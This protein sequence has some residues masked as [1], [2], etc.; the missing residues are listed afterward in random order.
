M[1]GRLADAPS[2][3]FVRTCNSIIRQ[4]AARRTEVARQGVRKARGKGSWSLDECGEPAAELAPCAAEIEAPP[5][6]DAVPGAHAT[7]YNY[8]N[9]DAGQAPW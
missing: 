3:F 6:S 1:A 9:C 7:I 5:L 4:I 2:L 8:C